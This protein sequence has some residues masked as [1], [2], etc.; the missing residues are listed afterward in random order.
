[1]ENKEIYTNE[2]MGLK[3]DSLVVSTCF[4]GRRLG[5][6]RQLL[7]VCGSKV[8]VKRKFKAPRQL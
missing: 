1:M 4:P 7:W 2:A 5:Q 8:A 3:G 6:L